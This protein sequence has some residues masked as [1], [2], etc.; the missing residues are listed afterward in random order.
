VSHKEAEL[1]LLS[2]LNWAYEYHYRANARILS[3]AADLSEAQF[4]ARVLPNHNSLRGTLVHTLSAEWIWLTRWQGTSPSAGLRA[5]DFPTLDS[6]RDRWHR[7][8][9]AVRAFLAA[10]SDD[11]L[12]R[13]LNYTNLKGTPFARPLW[14]VMLHV[15]NHGTQHR[16]EAAAMLT[17]LGH[18]PGDMDMTVLMQEL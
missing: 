13:N 12:Q 16:S 5:D 3:A 7:E 15:V 18:S 17:E 9:Q 11:G 1:T 4:N 6:I 10:Q 14:H 8:E 2:F